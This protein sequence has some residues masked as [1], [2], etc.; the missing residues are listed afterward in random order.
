MAAAHHSRV[1]TVTAHSRV[2]TVTAHSRVA[3]VTAHSR[4]ATVNRLGPAGKN[5][6]SRGR[7]PRL[8]LFFCFL[9][10][11]FFVFFFFFGTPRRFVPFNP[12]IHSPYPALTTPWPPKRAPGGT[13][14]VPLDG[15]RMFY[16]SRVLRRWGCSSP[17]LTIDDTARCLP[18]L[19]PPPPRK[20][21]RGKTVDGGVEK[22]RLWIKSSPR[23][24]LTLSKSY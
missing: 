1:A 19:R 5:K 13:L 7:R 8:F 9:G 4:V 16:T 15:P 14:I 6:F 10:G 23:I 17:G 12:T 21:E 22:L 2:A 18:P 24:R 20:H 3:T 11:R